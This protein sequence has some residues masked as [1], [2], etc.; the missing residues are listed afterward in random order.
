V[1][2]GEQRHI[3][4]GALAARQGAQT[5]DGC[6][7]DYAMR[8]AAAKDGPRGPRLGKGQRRRARRVFQFFFPEFFEAR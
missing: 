2:A 3:K 5:G 4:R 7:G 8:R 1:E 6:G